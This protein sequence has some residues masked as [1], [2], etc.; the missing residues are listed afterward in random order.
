MPL[1]CARLLSALLAL[2]AG[3]W[4]RKHER[5]I[6]RLGRPLCPEETA[7]ARSLGLNPE[8]IRILE[9]PKIPSPLGGLLRP[10]EE[11]VGF[12]LSN[13]AGVTLGTGIYLARAHRSLS[14]SRHELVHVAQY[15]R[16][17]GPTR[18]IYQYFL[19]CLT[20]GYHAAPLEREAVEL[21]SC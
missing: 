5:R 11:R 15:K 8:I 6:Q 17:R 12:C 10:I 21:S 14:L 1:F 2:P 18:F 13:A 3:L 9:L 19:E 16:L 7:F 20:V 4:I